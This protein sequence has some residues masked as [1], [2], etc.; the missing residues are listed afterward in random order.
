MI[1]VTNLRKIFFKNRQRLEVLKGIDLQIDSGETLAVVGVS[2]AG[3]T[4]LVHI[5]GTLDRPS[6]G[7]VTYE[8]QNVFL[9]DDRELARFR[10][11][12]VGF[13]FQFHHLLPE[14]TSL[15][16]VFLPA[17]IAGT[18][19]E[20]ARGKAMMLLDELGLADRAH[21]RPGELSGGEQQRVA[22]ARALVMAP[23]I[24][25]ADEPT[26]NLDTE[27]GRRVE[28]LLLNLNKS[29]GI[30]LIIVTHNETFA[31]RMSRTIRLDSGRLV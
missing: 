12:K 23:E 13:I 15:E 16:N 28:E 6:E 4:T 24:I 29:R 3:K 8:G 18:S 27:T 2:G 26:G 5:L 30:T 1:R 10:N 31:A 17:L 14:F 9:L 22:V 7:E 21:H 25:L 20:K 19:R 11:A